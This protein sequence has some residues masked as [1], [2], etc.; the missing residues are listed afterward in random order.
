MVALQLTLD[1]ADSQALAAF[2]D[3]TH[4]AF[5]TGTTNPISSNTGLNTE[6]Y[7]IALESSTKDTTNNQYT[8]VGRLP[9]PQANGST[10][11]EVGLFNS[12]SGGTMSVHI[13]LPTSY[14]KTSDDE[15]LVTIVIRVLSIN[16][17]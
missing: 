13:L 3:V 11:V 9:L 4:M 14:V 15:I 7:R 8:F 10:I 17:S 6:V 2:D 1:V 12:S 5:G 16:K